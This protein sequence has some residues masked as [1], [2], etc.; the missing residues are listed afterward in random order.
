M[1]AVTIKDGQLTVETRPDPIP[2]KGEL[3]VGVEAAG[4]NWAD[5]AQRMGLYP[6]PAGV[7]ADIPGLELAGV[8]RAV[9]EGVERFAVGDRVM[10][11]VGGGAQ[12]ELMTLHEREALAVPEGLPMLEAG[13]FAEAF[14]TA[15]DAL[16]TQCALGSG[17]RLL[18]NGAAG[19]VGLAGV[20]LAAAAGAEAI[21]SVRRAELRDAVAAFGATAVDPGEVAQYGPFDVVLELVGATNMEQDID[22]LAVGGRISVIGVI[23]GSRAEVDLR[24]LMMRRA[25]IHASTLRARPLEEKIAAARLVERHVLPLL[26][27]GTVRVPIEASYPLEAVEEAYGRFLEGGKLGKIVID[28]NA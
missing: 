12:A 11:V 4:L 18:V 22:C 25:H 14:T 27:S 28:I 8:V 13:G 9:G 20:Q 6:A 24:E 3:L 1:R 7:P 17:E 10:G 26:A 5:I 21:A 2:G 15:H 16:F 19:G 23:G